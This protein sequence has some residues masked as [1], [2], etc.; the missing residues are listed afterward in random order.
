MAGQVPSAPRQ[1]GAA[2]TSGSADHDVAD[3]G[4]DTE[5]NAAEDLSQFTGAESHPSEPVTRPADAG[6]GPSKTDPD[7]Q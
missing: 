4:P 3:E 5:P 7:T 6:Q 2:D 1:P